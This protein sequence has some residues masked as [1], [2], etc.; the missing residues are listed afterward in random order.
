MGVDATAVRACAATF[1][2]DPT[3]QRHIAVTKELQ[4]AEAAH[5]AN[6]SPATFERLRTARERHVQSSLGMAIPNITLEDC[7]E[8]AG[9]PLRGVNV[10]GR[11][12]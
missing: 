11:Q 12:P 10:S 8:R 2:T 1:N 9:L 5:A 6:P 3:V 4:G 7:L